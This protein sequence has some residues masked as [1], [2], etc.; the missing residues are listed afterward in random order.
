M[1]KIKINKRLGEIPMKTYIDEIMF[2]KMLK[3]VKN[4]VSQMN[5]LL[6][7]NYIRLKVNGSTVTAYTCDNYSV[8]KMTFEATR[9]EGDFECLIKPIPFK[10]SKGERKEVV[11]SLEDGV[12]QVEI[13]T[14]FGTLSYRFKQNV[15]M[16]MDFEKICDKMKS[17]DREIGINAN[18][19]ARIM[20]SF[21]S[22]VSD[23]HKLVILESKEN[24][25]EGFCMK[26][27]GEAFTLEQYLLPIKF[28]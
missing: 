6:E 18:L 19:M 26:T 25:R 5:H 15:Q 27:K 23:R 20:R 17:H 28:E 16:T 4:G 13:P 21:S 2:D 1:Q 9:S 22:I 8:T 10:V 14:E 3:A 7:L 24:N 12:A 11:L